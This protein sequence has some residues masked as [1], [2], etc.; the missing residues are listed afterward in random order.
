MGSGKVIKRA[1]GKHGIE[2]FTKVILETFDDSESMYAREKEIVNEKFLLREDVYN[3]R[4]GGYG[5]FDYLN[6]SSEAHI[7]RTKRG[8][9]KSLANID[10]SMQGKQTAEKN[11]K[12]KKGV[13]DPNFISS[14][15]KNPQ[16]QQMGNSPEAREKAKV[17]Q[18]KTFANT[19]H[20]QGEKN[21]NFG[22]MWIHN[23]TESRKIK[24]DDLMPEGWVKGRKMKF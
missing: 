15:V 5:G 1:I 8:Y 13:F 21:S 19:G 3:L 20:Q 14:W 11:R 10:L 23:D 6:D 18:R 7:E 24:K 17:T 4:C 22:T 9:Q 12:N 16:L 2:N